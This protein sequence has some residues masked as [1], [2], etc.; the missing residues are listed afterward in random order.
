MIIYLCALNLYFTESFGCSLTC[1]TLNDKIGKKKK[2][3]VK[4]FKSCEI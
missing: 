2:P 1:M 3:S 4:K